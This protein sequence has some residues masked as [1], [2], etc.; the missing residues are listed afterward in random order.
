MLEASA[1]VVAASLARMRSHKACMRMLAAEGAK[2]TA[3]APVL[4]EVAQVGRV[5]VGKRALL[6]KPACG[7][8]PPSLSAMGGGSGTKV[9]GWMLRSRL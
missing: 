2:A 9:A 4:P 1:V 7:S 8:K 5:A 6:L 3:L